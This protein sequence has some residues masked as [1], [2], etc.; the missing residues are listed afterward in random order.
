MDGIKGKKGFVLKDRNTSVEETFFSLVPSDSD[1]WVEK[2]IEAI[3]SLAAK[4]PTEDL[5]C[6]PLNNADIRAEA[7][8]SQIDNNSIDDLLKDLYTKNR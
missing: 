7:L 8:V 3:N 1:K 5:L 4:Q 2:L 6:E